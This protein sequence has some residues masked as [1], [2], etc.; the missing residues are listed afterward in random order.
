MHSDLMY[1]WGP[2]EVSEIHVDMTEKVIPDSQD[3]T[4]AIETDRILSE[5]AADV[6]HFNRIRTEMMLLYALS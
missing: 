2:D 1:L 3:Q 5:R 4:T 6:C